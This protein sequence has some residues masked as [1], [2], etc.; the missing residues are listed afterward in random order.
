MGWGFAP[1]T[2]GPLSFIDTIGPKKFVAEADR[3]SQTYGPRFSPPQ[4][5]RVMADRGET[6]YS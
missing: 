5:L 2:G 3:L 1:W 6:Y 4:S